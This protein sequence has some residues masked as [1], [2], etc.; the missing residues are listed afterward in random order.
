[1]PP[2]VPPLPRRLADPRPVVGIGTLAWFTAAVVL[3]VARGPSVWLAACVT[4][5]LLGLLGFAM[6]HAQRSAARRGA[7]SAQQG[8]L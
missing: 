7:R 8:M 3:L 1:M 6:I 5:S 4:G 2:V